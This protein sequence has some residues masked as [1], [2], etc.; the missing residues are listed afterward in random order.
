MNEMK[1]GMWIECRL[2]VVGFISVD[3]GKLNK[4]L[5]SAAANGQSEARESGSMLGYFYWKKCFSNML[6][7]SW[8]NLVGK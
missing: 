2:N 7:T 1:L 8:K 3:V 4:S 5:A 6:R